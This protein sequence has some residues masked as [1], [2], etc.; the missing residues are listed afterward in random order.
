MKTRTKLLVVAAILALFTPVLLAPSAWAKYV[1]DGAVPNGVTGGWDLPDDRGVCVTGIKSDG[2]VIIDTSITSRPDCI[3]RTFPAYTTSAACK[4]S[5]SAGANVEGSHYWTKSC[6]DASG[7][8]I[9]LSGLDRN[10]NMC[11]QNGGT[12]KDSCTSAWTYLGPS[13]DGTDGFC[14]TK[15]RL[16]NYDQTT[17]PTTTFG[18]T[19]DATNG[20]IYN[21]GI[22][23]KANAALTKMDGTTF[24]AAGANVDLAGLDMGQCLF[25]GATFSNH[26]TAGGTAPVATTD[27]A[28]STIATPITNVRA[29]CLSCHNNTSQY[30][31]YKGRWKSDY[32]KTGHKNMLR[33]VTPGENWAGPDGVVYTEAAGNQILDFVNGLVDGAYGIGKKLMYIFGDWM[34]PAPEGLDTIVGMDAT[35]AKYNGTSTYSCAACHTTGWR[36]ED[37]TKGLCSQSSKTTQATCEAAGGTWYPSTGAQGYGIGGAE[38]VASFPSMAT[39]NTIAGITGQWDI[40][41]IVCTRCHAV[42][43]DPT[44]P[45][46]ENGVN[47]APGHT[48]HETDIFNGFTQTNIC[49]GCHQSPAKTASGTGADV[50]LNHPEYIPV[51]NTATAPEYVPEFSGHVLGNSFLNSPHAKFTGTIVPNALG[52][53]DMVAGSTFASTFMGKVCRSST[54]VGGGSVLETTATGGTIK[55]LE[56]CNR[57]NGKPVGDTTNYGY[58]QDENGGSCS[59]CHDVHQSVVPAVGA[60]EPIRRECATCHVDDPAS[61]PTATPIGGINHPG[62]AGTPLEYE[63]TA[64][65]HAC[66]VCHMPKATDSGFPMHLW[67]INADPGYSTFPTAAEFGIGATATKK[68]AN[69]SPD[70]GYASAVWVDLDLTCGQCHGPSGSAHLISKGSIAYFAGAMHAQGGGIPSTT[71]SDCHAKTL[72]HETAP[73]TPSQCSTCHG[74]TRPGVKPTVAAACITCHAPSGPAHTF[75]EAQIAPY[76]AAIH[77]GGSFPANCGECHTAFKMKSLNHP[78]NPT[79]GTPSCKDCHGKGG[80]IPTV[81]AA[82][83]SCHGGSAGPKAAKPGVPYLTAADLAKVA[84]NI[85]R[86]S[87]PKAS[88]QVVATD[89]KPDV[90]GKQVYVGDIVQV[91]DTSV[92]GTNNLTKIKVKWGDGTVTVIAPGGSATHAYSATGSMT[93]KLVAIDAGGLTSS[94]SKQIVVKAPAL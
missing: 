76:A 40:D 51:K 80:Q 62:G 68:N 1:G 79:A 38:P 94:V 15:I 43:Y 33:K 20:C 21:Y 26:T 5:D 50:D 22:Q 37:T 67:R 30:N 45:L 60:H 14:Y 24:A 2:T 25:N 90:A 39:G 61:Y 34:A 71:C 55:T 63:A 59:T 31:S 93:I 58:W 11:A 32:L 18:Y 54:S 91:N 87:A 16:D 69:T 89:R 70:S 57:A 12:W 72:A 3:A 83:N 84:A 66:E 85:H 6:V 52:K 19:W 86:D 48:T 8:G 49:Y 44:L 78:N 27:P 65:S 81:S 73:G 42:T 23:G 7:S 47:A 36:N 29:G 56:D 53:Y 13:L 64:P 9:S 46:N 17:C 4:T 41:G 74:T 10:A 88:M 35:S 77:A 92:A 28:G 82:C 75:T